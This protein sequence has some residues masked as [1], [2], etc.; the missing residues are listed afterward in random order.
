MVGGV[1]EFAVDVFR[2]DELDVLEIRIEVVQGDPAA[3]AA[4]VAKEIHAGIGVRP[5][6]QPVE[7]GSL[8][9]FDLKARRFRDHRPTDG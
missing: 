7:A 2:R 4:E 6:V 3:T 9:R 5:L 8:P 1:S